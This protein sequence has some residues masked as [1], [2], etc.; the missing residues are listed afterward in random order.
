MD[1]NNRPMKNINKHIKDTN[2]MSENHTVP[3]QIYQMEELSQL[4]EF[5]KTLDENLLR[6][7]LVKEYFRLTEYRDANE[8]NRLVRICE[9]FSIIG[10]GNLERVDAKCVKAL[11]QWLTELTNK[12]KETRFLQGHWVKR[13]N[14]YVLFNP[15]YFYS[16]DRPEK[17]SIDWE[18]YPKQAEIECDVPYLAKQRNKQ[19]VNPISFGG[20][21]VSGSKVKSNMLFPLLR[22][23]RILFDNNLKPDLYG[24]GLNSIDI[25]YLTVE[26]KS[27]DKTHFECGIYYPKNSTYRCDIFFGNDYASFSEQERKEQIKQ[28]VFEVLQDVK[29]RITKRKL[30]YNIDLL[31]KDAAI[32]IEK[33]IK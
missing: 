17:A 1:T 25:R 7:N 5:V 29:A 32:E 8:W 2:A 6:E 31:T 27:E 26:E 3:E 22:A 18:S 20:I 24:E 21:F 14:G 15:C 10:W 23:L 33:W 16:P 13:K 19:K 11:N 30:N 9:V 12:Q 4:E 28:L